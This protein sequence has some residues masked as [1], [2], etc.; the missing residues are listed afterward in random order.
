M[1]YSGKVYQCHTSRGSYPFRANGRGLARKPK[2]THIARNSHF[3]FIRKRGE[4]LRRTRRSGRSRENNTDTDIPIFLF[5]GRGHGHGHVSVS[6]LSPTRLI[7]MYGTTRAGLEPR[8][9]TST[10]RA[11][12]QSSS[13]IRRSRMLREVCTCP[14]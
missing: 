2:K 1:R 13:F 3:L 7:D 10:R 8:T 14:P 4:S 12:L 6:V 11:R 9:L 5:D